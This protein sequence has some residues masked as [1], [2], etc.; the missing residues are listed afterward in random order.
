MNEYTVVKKKCVIDII[1]FDHMMNNHDNR[2]H[3]S[4]ALGRMKEY[5]KSIVQTIV[6]V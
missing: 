4:A 3:D 5:Q 2:M 1:G 6:V